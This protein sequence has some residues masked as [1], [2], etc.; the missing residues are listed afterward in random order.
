VRQLDMRLRLFF[1]PPFN[2]FA[3]TSAGV[4]AVSTLVALRAASQILARRGQAG[5]KGE[6]AMGDAIGL[7]AIAV[8]LLIVGFGA[9][10]LSG[11]VRRPLTL[12][13]ILLFAVLAALFVT[14]GT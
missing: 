5:P 4:A 6:M 13:H 2:R 10:L 1:M 9:A 14:I 7:F 11:P 8:P 3:K 12:I